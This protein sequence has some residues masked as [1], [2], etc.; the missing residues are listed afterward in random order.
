MVSE[1]DV[2]REAVNGKYDSTIN[3]S[4]ILQ[5]SGSLQH[6]T[7]TDKSDNKVVCFSSSNSP[8]KTKNSPLINLSNE[9]LLT[10]FKH[11]SAKDRVALVLTSRNLH[12][13]LNFELYKYDVI[14][15]PGLG[16]QAAVENASTS[17]GFWGSKS[18]LFLSV[19]KFLAAGADINAVHKWFDNGP[20]GKTALSNALEGSSVRTLRI[21][22]ENGAILDD[23]CAMGGST[24][25]GQLA[26][27]LLKFFSVTELGINSQT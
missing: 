13:R 23:S 8:K 17:L 9:L 24:A 14:D 26:E 1:L 22:L 16:L 19:R 2:L 5:T 11:L 7:R 25:L 10:I 6:K 3:M 4:D 18:D 15:R 20:D 27:V 21:L 12:F